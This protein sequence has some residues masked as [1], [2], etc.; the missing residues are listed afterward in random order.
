MREFWFSQEID[1]KFEQE[2]QAQIKQQRDEEQL[3]FQEKLSINEEADML[4]PN[5]QTSSLVL[6]NSGLNRS[7]LSRD[8]TQYFNNLPKPTKQ[9]K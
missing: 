8:T 2:R 3:G 1:D 6:I 5:Q 7:G 9:I 4:E